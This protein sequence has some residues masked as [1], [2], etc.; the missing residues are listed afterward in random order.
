MAVA[1]EVDM[2]ETK[3]KMVMIATMNSRTSSSLETTESRSLSDAVIA[4]RS[5]PISTQTAS[6]SSIEISPFKSLSNIVKAASASSS[7]SKAGRRSSD[8]TVSESSACLNVRYNRRAKTWEPEV[9]PRSWRTLQ[10]IS[11]GFYFGHCET[12]TCLGWVLDVTVLPVKSPATFPATS[13][14]LLKTW[15]VFF[16]AFLT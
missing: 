11:A 7:L 10:S 5:R 2:I 15:R 8:S 1:A 13:P 4:F 16:W 12:Y 9:L 6:S 14:T 3:T